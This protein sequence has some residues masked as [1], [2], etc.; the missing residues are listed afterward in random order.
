MGSA[1]PASPRWRSSSGSSPPSYASRSPAATSNGTCS[2]RPARRSSPTTRTGRSATC[3]KGS[4]IA[5]GI[6]RHA[7]CRDRRSRPQL[8]RRR[9]EAEARDRGRDDR[10]LRWVDTRRAGGGAGLRGHAHPELRRRPRQLDRRAHRGA[11]SALDSDGGLVSGI[12]GLV[13]AASRSGCRCGRCATRAPSATALPSA[14]PATPRRCCRAVEKLDAD[15]HE[16]G[17]VTRATAPLW[18][19][20]PA[21]VLAG[22][23]TRATRRLSESLLLD[24]R[25]AAL[26]TLAHLDPT[27]PATPA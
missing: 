15:T 14:S 19:E 27:E 16:V 12:V 4:R 13:R 7:V 23:S 18:I 8:V 5:A 1:S 25:I 20:F 2:P 3:S 22:G 17:R 11:I 26:R 9:H 24:E 10:S 6:H 21:K